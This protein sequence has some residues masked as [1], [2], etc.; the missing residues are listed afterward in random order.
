LDEKDVPDIGE[1]TPVTLL[2]YDKRKH[3]NTHDC[4]AQNQFVLELFGLLLN[5]LEQEGPTPY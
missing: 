4:E 1:P 5:S 2:F 3:Q